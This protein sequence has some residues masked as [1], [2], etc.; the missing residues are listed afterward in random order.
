M[1]GS[2]RHLTALS[3]QTWNIIREP[4]IKPH[5]QFIAGK[6]NTAADY[7]SRHFNDRTDWKLNQQTFQKIDSLF[8]PHKIDLFATN[9]STQLPRYF[10]HFAY[11]Q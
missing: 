4:N 7:W 8:G 9:Q 5:F 11:P 1:G 3:K 6:N 10:R 2:H